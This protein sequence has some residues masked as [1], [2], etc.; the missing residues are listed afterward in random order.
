M[1]ALRDPAAAL[2]EQLADPF[3]C[4]PLGAQARDKDSVVVVVSDY[5]RY[6]AYPK[7]LSVLLDE[8]NDSGI[9]DRAIQLYV[10]SGT[11][12][13]ATDDEK[14]E[15]VGEEV[16]GRVEMLDHDCDAMGRMMKIGR[17]GYGTIAYV[18][19]RVFDA[20]LLILT[21]GI[22]YHYF[23]GYSGGRKAVLPGCC[24]RQTI[25]SNH[26]LA[27]DPETGDFRPTVRPGALVGNPVN[28]D[29]LQIA[30][31]LRPDICVNVVLNG[32][33]EI[34]WLGVGDHGYMLRTGA[35]FLDD[36]RRI[37]VA[38]PADIAI[39]GAGGYPKDLSLFQAHKSL[40]HSIAALSPGAKVFW[41]AACEHGE[42]TEEFQSYRPLSLDEVRGKVQYHVSLSSICS[43]SLKRLAH[44]H[45][46]HLISEL[47]PDRVRAWG[48]VPHRDI[49][50]A[51][52]LALP[53]NA[54]ALGWLIAPDFSSMLAVPPA[55]PEED[56]DHD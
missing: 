34:A 1:P 53:A 24:A 5:T 50:Q 40:R 7:W 23:A 55:P 42:G 35:Q 30:N 46:V 26:R 44:D 52:G 18:D 51:L 15:L 12:R 54:A 27:L 49:N 38:E 36:H 4:A 6:H 20:Q 47:E 29:M 17:T 22:T 31:Q 28:E 37:E 19:K 56:Q 45:E 10:G 11:H 39:I 8:L 13:Q 48:L 25:L 16:H 3:G 32:E 21:G 2:R 33:R 9:P 43:L 14:R 41:L